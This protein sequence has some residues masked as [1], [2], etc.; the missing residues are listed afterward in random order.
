MA[1]LKLINNS[2]LREENN[3]CFVNTSLQLLYSI[4]EIRDFFKNKAYKTDLTARLPLSDEIS[5][6]FKTEGRYKTSAA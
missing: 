5:R 6:I 2:G 3:L 4:P 1:V